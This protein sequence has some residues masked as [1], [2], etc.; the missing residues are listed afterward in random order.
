MW[1]L[2][3]IELMFHDRKCPT[4]IKKLLSIMLHILNKYTTTKFQCKSI[5]SNIGSIT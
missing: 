4:S 1:I 3:S 2:T 5:K